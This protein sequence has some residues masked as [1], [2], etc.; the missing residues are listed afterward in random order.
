MR[1]INKRKNYQNDINDFLELLDKKIKEHE[2][3]ED[4]LIYKEKIKKIFIIN[5]FSNK[6]YAGDC[7][8]N[9]N[10]III[11]NYNKHTIYHELL[12][13]ISNGG[14]CIKPTCEGINEGYTELL[15]SRLLIEDDYKSSIPYQTLKIVA[16]AVEDIIGKNLM[17]KYYFTANQKGFITTLLNYT[18]LDD[19]N[20]FI[21]ACDYICCY[22]NQEKNTTKE[23]EKFQTRSKEIHDFLISCF[24]N[25][26]EQEYEQNLITQEDFFNKLFNFS[27]KLNILYNSN[28]CTLIDFGPLA[29]VM[30][31]DYNEIVETAKVELKKEKAFQK[32]L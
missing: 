28:E 16:Q 11:Y 22:N 17:Q 8:Y 2:I 19:V 6:K 32:R 1:I 18:S 12:H 5:L 20:K 13:L 7:L 31:N 3:C 27:K 24:K 23:I 29:Y 26:L 10:T 9:I 30:N 15:T 25:K 21:N 4:Y 14:F